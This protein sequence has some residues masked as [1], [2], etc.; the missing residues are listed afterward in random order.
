MIISSLLTFKMS[1]GDLTVNLR[2]VFSGH[3]QR[4]CWEPASI[5][6]V[7]FPKVLRFLRMWSVS[8]ARIANYL[9]RP[10]MK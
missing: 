5:T 7:T 9:K 4:I 3:R 8:I 1:L 10:N 2:R 6:W